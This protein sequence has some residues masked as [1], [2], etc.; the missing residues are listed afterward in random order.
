M[1]GMTK[2]LNWTLSLLARITLALISSSA[3][4]VY[5]QKVNFQE[6]DLAIRNFESPFTFLYASCEL[7]EN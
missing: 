5:F 3:F 6:F 1:I 2:F 7:F 4:I